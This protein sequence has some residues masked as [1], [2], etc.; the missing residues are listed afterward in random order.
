MGGTVTVAHVATVIATIDMATLVTA[1]VY[2]C[3][4]DKS[5]RPFYAIN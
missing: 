4:G 2:V 3:G 5:H 1:M